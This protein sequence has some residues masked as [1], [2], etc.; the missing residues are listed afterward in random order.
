[1]FANFV[2]VFLVLAFQGA[3]WIFGMASVLVYIHVV[4]A[5]QDIGSKGGDV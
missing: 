4:V 3:N 1:M 5:L 2:H